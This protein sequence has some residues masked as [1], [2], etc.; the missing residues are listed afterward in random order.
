MSS[1][2]GWLI[3]LIKDLYQKQYNTLFFTSCG[4][5]DF[6]QFDCLMNDDMRKNVEN[7]IIWNPHDPKSVKIDIVCSLIDNNSCY[8]NTKKI[9][10][11]NRV[12][13]NTSESVINYLEKLFVSNE[14]FDSTKTFSQHLLLQ[15]FLKTPNYQK[16]NYINVMLENI[17]INRSKSS[18]LDHKMACIGKFNLPDKYCVVV[19]HSN[20]NRCFNG[21]DYNAMLVILNKHFSMK[22]VI[23]GFEKSNFSNPNVIN[24]SKLTNIQE[25][26]EIVKNA[27]AYI[28]VDTCFTVFAT[29]L[30]AE[31]KI[32]I[33][34]SQDKN[35]LKF[36]YF[37]KKN[38]NK[39]LHYKII[40]SF[41]RNNLGWV[42]TFI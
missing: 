28:G 9:I 8:G 17:D 2:K 32:V 7:I 38:I 5:G 13:P 27:D 35:L 31:N 24:L 41:N 3:L 23:I 11:E 34:S 1:L 37:T 18:F 39:F 29:Q 10:L 42:K 21:E 14:F 4:I 30:F 15:D 16:D 19:P 33:K 36:F 26:I 25:S 22:G 12:H 6:L 20:S 40:D